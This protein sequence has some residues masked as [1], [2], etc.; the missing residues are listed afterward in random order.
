MGF[1]ITWDGKTKISVEVREAFYK[2]RI[3][4]LCGPM[5]DQP[6]RFFS[7]G[8]E[9]M[10]VSNFHLKWADDKRIKSR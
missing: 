1:Y 7:S 9:Y 4:G 3:Q 6:G 10:G 2:N 5:D 8:G